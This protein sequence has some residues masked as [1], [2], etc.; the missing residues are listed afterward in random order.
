[1]IR[2]VHHVAVSTPDIEAQI[3]WYRDA[4]GFELVSRGA[5]EAGNPMIDD[6]VGL[7]GSSAMTATMR[8]ANLFVELFQYH[9]PAGAPGGRSAADHGYTHF[10]LDVVDI[11]AEM[12]RL[13]AHGMTFHGPLA[14]AGRLGGGKIRAMYGRDPWGNIIELQE[15]VDPS[16]HSVLDL[17]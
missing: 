14:P 2:G 8:A 13:E 10:C 3:A 6:I 11:E 5:W 15:V 4:L 9:S 12:A 17:G 16:Y 1:M 7:P